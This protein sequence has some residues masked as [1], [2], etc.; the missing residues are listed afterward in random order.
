[1]NKI[2]VVIGAN[3]GDEGKGHFT[4][5]LADPSTLVVRFNGGAQAGHT[6]MTPNL[7]RHVFHHFGAGLLKGS[8]TFLSKHF[9]VNPILFRE[10]RQKL[11]GFIIN[12]SVDPRALVTTPYDMMI[13]A[14]VEKKRSA[15]N[16]KHG[17]CGIGINETVTRSATMPI[18]YEDLTRYTVDELLE[19][20]RRE[21][22]PVRLAQLG[23]EFDDLPYLTNKGIMNSWH[24]DV[25]HMLKHAPSQWW[26]RAKDTRERYIFEGAQGLAL[27][28]FA[29]G[30][31]HVTRS[32]TGLTNVMAMLSES[33]TREEM[34]VHY[35]TRPYM[36]RH[37]AGGLGLATTGKP[38]LGIVDKTNVNNPHQGELRFGTLDVDL[39]VARIKR[40]VGG[41]SFWASPN[42]GMTCIDQVP[43]RISVMMDNVLVKINT[44]D[45]PRAIATRVGECSAHTHFNGETREHVI[46]Q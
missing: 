12:I 30:F 1:M 8:P 40:D 43:D 31:P 22:V 3:Y 24:D 32:R 15:S 11:N 42:I 35:I 45:L 26:G 41:N 36:T 38:Y 39:L 4:D 16:M 6:V 20:V 23:L 29:P 44:L 25:F 27:D 46:H 37:G 19:W 10:E 5:Y 14:A 28:E 34:D 7:F 2:Q 33:G 9:I 13:N 21:W 18:H 17:S